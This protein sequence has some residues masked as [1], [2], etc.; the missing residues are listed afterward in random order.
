MRTDVTVETITRDW[1]VAHKYDGLCAENCGCGLDDFMC[2]LPD[3]DISGCVPAHKR[4]ATQADID[5]GIDCE[6]GDQIFSADNE[7]PVDARPHLR[8]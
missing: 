4:K 7:D 5:N 6:L 2:C 3:M 1:L 8:L